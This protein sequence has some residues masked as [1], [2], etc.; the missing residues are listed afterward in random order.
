MR[1]DAWGIPAQ[2]VLVIL[3]SLQMLSCSK[4]A[5]ASSVHEVLNPC[6]YTKLEHQFIAHWKN[7]K[8]S[9]VYDENIK[10]FLQQNKSDLELLEPNYLLQSSTLV[11]TDTQI[12]PYSLD[13]L[14]LSPHDI[15]HT[16]NAWDQGILGQRIT[17]AVID[18]GIDF[19]H[20]QL[21][22]HL[23]VN[24]IENRFGLNQIDDDGNGYIDDINGWNFV[25]DSAEQHDEV[26][27]GTAMAGI[28][29]GPSEN[30]TSLS[31]APE[32]KI[33]SV[34]F[35]DQEGG[36]E[37]H[38]H[39]AM[40]YALSRKVNI[41]NNSWS[42]SCS[43][44]LKNDFINWSKENVIFVN[45]SGNTPINVYQKGIIPSSLNLPNNLNV[46][47]LNEQGHISTFSGFG[48]SVKIFAPGEQIPTIFPDSGMS[49]SSPASGTSVS[50]A[51]VSG[52]AAL[53][54]S[55]FPEA[56]AIQ[57]ISLIQDGAYVDSSFHRI[58]DIKKSIWLGKQRFRPSPLIFK[59]M[60]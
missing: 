26:G 22:P 19:T 48:E 40:A 42:I 6:Q 51:I 8:K 5:D 39:E 47:S 31:M 24:E 30:R 36:T 20:P 23:A 59:D 1:M 2:S 41:I 33:L 14:R 29:T 35:M 4:K 38:A 17:V 18:T 53:V 3:L 37:F 45:A 16:Q 52:A 55:A 34:D 21:N 12:N 15:I 11:L 57:I 10:I 58:L 28:I 9:L 32:A 50:T 56:T 7:G 25:T 44:L 43:E 27:H 54:W 60:D 49:S 46:G 13:P